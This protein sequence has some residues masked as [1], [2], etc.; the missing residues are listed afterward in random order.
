V[1]DGTSFWFDALARERNEAEVETAKQL[2][3]AEWRSTWT[4]RAA[5]ADDPVAPL[6]VAQLQRLAS[7]PLVTLGA[8]TQTHLILARAPREVQAT[9][10]RGSLDA[11]ASWTGVRP[12][13]FA[14]PNGR[15]GVDFDAT[16]MGLV[17]SASARVAFTTHPAFARSD[18]PPMARSRFLMLANVDAAEL[19]HRL[20]VTW[21]RW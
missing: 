21:P 14:Y 3:F 19:A 18:E 1:R 11:L 10:I 12:V 2:S 17:A 20:M 6:D 7:H 4:T 16:T 15:P 9:E 8:H 13:A 5:A